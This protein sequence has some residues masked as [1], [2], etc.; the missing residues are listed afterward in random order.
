MCVHVYVRV[1]ARVCTCVYVCVWRVCTC[2]HVWVYA[3]GVG[4]VEHVCDV[5][6][7]TINTGPHTGED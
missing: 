1:C 3:C 7:K 6:D 5:C 2:V 4:D